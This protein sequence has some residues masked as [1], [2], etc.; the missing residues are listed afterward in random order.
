MKEEKRF[1]VHRYEY[2]ILEFGDETAVDQRLL[3]CKT[4]RSR[5]QMIGFQIQSHRG[6]RKN[7]LARMVKGFLRLGSTT[8]NALYILDAFAFQTWEAIN[9]CNRKRN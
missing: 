6:Q 2:V 1:R 9:G 7:H 5:L 3:V 8:A 4:Q